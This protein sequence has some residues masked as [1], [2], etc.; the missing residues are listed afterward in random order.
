MKAIKLLCVFAILASCQDLD[1]T[2]YS[3]IYTENFYKNAADAEKGLLSAYGALG[4]LGGVPV[5]LLV[6]EFSA[7]Q[8]YPRPVVGRNTLTQFS[9]DVNYTAQQTAGRVS[10]SPQSIWSFS[11]QGIENANWVIEKVPG[12]TM[13]ELRK[14]Q[15]IGEAYFLRAYYHWLL[16]KNFG[17]IPVKIRPS[18]SEEEAIVGKSP[19]SEVYRQIYEDLD[20]ASEAGFL[21]FPAVD[22]GRPSKEAVDALYA[23]VALYNEDWPLALEKSEAVINSGKYTLMTNVRDLYELEKEDE[24]RAENIWAFEGDR[25]TPGRGTSFNRLLG[26]PGSNA[27]EYAQTTFGSVFAYQ[28][29]FDS[30][31]PNDTRR[32]LLDTN[33]VDKNGGIVAQKDITPI[34][35][36]AVLIEKYMDPI[37]NGPGNNIPILRLADVYLIAAEAEFRM[38]G[39]SQKALDYLNTV[40]RRAF[41]VPLDSPSLYDR[42]VITLDDILQERSWEFFAEGDRWYD[43]TRTDQFLIVIPDAVNEVFPSRPVQAKHKFF[44]IPEEEVNA[45]PKLSQ[46]PDWN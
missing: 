12:A 35:Q 31:D 22:D 19:K 18:N 32:S 38:N 30:F 40:R 45:N 17:E 21:S 9:Y 5:M 29:F 24:A 27:P 13:D 39:S 6:P 4:S 20:H 15:I 37:E 34:T 16:A 42:T 26:P 28:A 7:D 41:G 14:R 44:P 2:V 36:N 8:L 10:E 33:Y 11:Y 1:E 43:L 25:T 46:N 3:S 23:K